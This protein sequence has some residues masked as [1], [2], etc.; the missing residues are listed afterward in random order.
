MTKKSNA[1]L[2]CANR[3]SKILLTIPHIIIFNCYQSSYFEESDTKVRT[4]SPTIDRNEKSHFFSTIT[5]STEF[6]PHT[7]W[8][9]KFLNFGGVLVDV[10]TGELASIQMCIVSRKSLN[11]SSKRSPQTKQ[12]IREKKSLNNVNDVCA[13]SH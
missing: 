6:F 3:N 2:K 7:E 13:A 8:S 9:Q 5:L 10:A 11:Q 1:V 12:K 4:W